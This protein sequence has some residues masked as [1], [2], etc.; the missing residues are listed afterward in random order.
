MSGASIKLQ[1]AEIITATVAEQSRTKVLF[2][3]G[4][5]VQVASR[6]HA[7]CLRR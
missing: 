7:L 3:A 5:A 1:Q 4:A 6:T 2:A